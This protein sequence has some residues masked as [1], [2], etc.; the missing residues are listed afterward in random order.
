LMVLMVV[1]L[2]PRQ[3]IVWGT[4]L[5]LIRPELTRTRR[6]TPRPVL[7]VFLWI[8]R[9]GD[10]LAMTVTGVVR[11]IV[12]LAAVLLAGV[13][14]IVLGDV[15]LASSGGPTRAL[16]RSRGARSGRAISTTPTLP[17]VPSCLDPSSG[18]PNIDVESTI[19]VNPADAG[20]LIA[21]W[22]RSQ[23]AFPRPD[24]VAGGYAVTHDGGRSWTSGVPAMSMAARADLSIR[25]RARTMGLW[26]SRPTAGVRTCSSSR[27]GRWG[28]AGTNFPQNPLLQRPFVLGD[29]SLLD[30]FDQQNFFNA[31]GLRLEHPAEVIAIRSRDHGRTWS[32]PVLIANHS[33]YPRFDDPDGGPPVVAPDM[34][35][36]ATAPD[37]TVYVAWG[38]RTGR[39][40]LLRILISDSRNGGRSWSPPTKV[41]RTTTAI[42]GPELAVTGNGTIG[43][44]YYDVRHDHP[45]DH[46]WTTD[47]YLAYCRDHTARWHEVHIAGP[48]NLASSPEHNG[49]VTLGNNFYFGLAGLPSGFAAAFPIARPNAIHGPTDIFFARITLRPYDR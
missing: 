47:V 5:P 46:F 18:P 34:A 23:A 13:A 16:A 45:G 14:A 17:R 4:R 43:V 3:M 12:C 35:S 38:E 7:V 44:L 2:V 21:L 31:A 6:V 8:I 27:G 42:A 32:R 20:N 9:S 26:C 39:R 15:A 37:G 30:V 11:V 10:W 24:P 40:R 33:P 25:L 1:L 19:A 22:A 36:A 49:R 28:A 48:F 41:G 29:G